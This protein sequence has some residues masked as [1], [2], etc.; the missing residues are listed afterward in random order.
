MANKKLLGVLVDVENKKVDAI[1]IADDLEKYYEVLNC[2][3]I[4]IVQ[5]RIGQKK[6]TIICDD[7][8]LFSAAPKI[9]AINNLGQ[10]QLVGN[11]FIVAA[12]SD[13]DGNLI[14]LSKSEAEYILKRCVKLATKNYPDPYPMLTQC[15]Y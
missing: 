11:L 1:E 5:R 15:E 3:C 8:G 6:F 13:E 9:S 7:E 4:D 12:G 2:T 14:G 10:A